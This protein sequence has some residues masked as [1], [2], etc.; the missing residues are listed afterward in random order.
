MFSR[1]AQSAKSVME[2]T[3]LMITDKFIIEFKSNKLNI[4]TGTG[5]SLVAWFWLNLCLFANLR[6]TGIRNSHVHNHDR[7]IGQTEISARGVSFSIF[8]TSSRRSLG[9]HV[10]R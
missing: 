5:G 2:E 8:Q 4:G 1:F 3:F 6:L 10:S 7:S 9:I